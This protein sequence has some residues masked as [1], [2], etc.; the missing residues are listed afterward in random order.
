MDRVLDVPRFSVDKVAGAAG[1][2]WDVL[3]LENLDADLR[4]PPAALEA[5]RSVLF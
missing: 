4:P 5:K 2:D 3:R 1:A